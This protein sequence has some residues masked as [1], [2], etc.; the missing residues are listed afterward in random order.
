MIEKT[1]K[2]YILKPSTLLKY[3]KRKKISK[4]ENQKEPKGTKTNDDSLND[5]DD[6]LKSNTFYQRI[7][8]KKKRLSVLNFVKLMMARYYSMNRKTYF[9]DPEPNAK[10][11]KFGYRYAKEQ[12]F[13]KLDRDRWQFKFKETHVITR[14]TQ[15]CTC[16]YFV[17][18]GVC[19]HLLALNRLCKSDE[20]VNKPKRG[21]QKKSKNSLIRD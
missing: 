5:V 12:Y 4:S 20:L 7:H 19:G 21:G 9:E 10:C 14:S 11:K 6:D 17:K 15:N 3:T 1:N 13:I 8:T 16:K 18:S 2:I